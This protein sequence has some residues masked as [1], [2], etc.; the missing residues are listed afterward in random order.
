MGAI[1]SALHQMKSS[2]SAYRVMH[3]SLTLGAIL[4]YMLN[5]LSFRPAEGQRETDLTETCCW[6]LYPDDTDSDIVESDEEE[7]PVPVML[8]FGLY[9]ISGVFLQEGIALRMGGGDTVTMDSIMRLYKVQNDQDL[10]MAFQANGRVN[11]D[12]ERNN[13][14]QNR[15]RVPVDVRLVASKEELVAQDTP[16]ADLGIRTSIQQQEVGPD[17]APLQDDEMDDQDEGGQ[18]KSVGGKQES[19][20]DMVARIWRQFPYDLFENAPNHRFSDQ[21]SH[22]LLSEED[23]KEATIEWFCTTDLRRIFD[24]VAI[25]VVTPDKWKGLIFKRYFPAKGFVPPARFQNFLRLRY[26][27]EWNALMESLSV[28]QAK[29]VRSSVWDT[30]KTLKWLPLTDADRLWNTKTLKNPNKKDWTFLPCNDKR[31]VVQIGLNGRLLQDAE[32][33]RISVG[34][35]GQD[36]RMEVD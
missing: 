29:V 36:Y 34:R 24:R 2:P 1:Y 25:K 33:I 35:V 14:T 11:N 17:I 16:L 22:L 4:I 30:F 6:N 32:S 12:S 10:Q 9:F 23:R 13:R 21:S 7:Q 28:E 19:V 26:F 27:Q 20:D 8:D 15:R 5:A 31:P 18:Q 3:S